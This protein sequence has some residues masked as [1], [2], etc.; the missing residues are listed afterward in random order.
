[1][2][3]R[4]SLFAGARRIVLCTVVNAELVP[5]I[6]SLRMVSYTIAV[7]VLICRRLDQAVY[8]YRK[9]SITTRLAKGLK[10]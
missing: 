10:K 9:R 7:I 1:M 3:K 4:A 5:I 8:H 6:I 2:R